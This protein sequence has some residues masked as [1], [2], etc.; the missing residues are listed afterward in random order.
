ME[1]RVAMYPGR[2][3]PFHNGH[4]AIIYYFW[5]NYGNIPV[6]IGAVNNGTRTFNNPF[7][8]KEVEEIINRSLSDL[9][10]RDDCQVRLV[11]VPEEN[12]GKWLIKMLKESKANYLLTGNRN[13]AELAKNVKGLMVINPIDGSISS[14]RSSTVRDLTRNDSPERRELVTESAYEFIDQLDIDWRNLS[15]ENKRS[16]VY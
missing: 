9:Q 4:V 1:R 16:W 6:V 14:I 5:Q 13:M 7:L 8:G 10:L 11:D 15:K 12:I 3:Q 2:F